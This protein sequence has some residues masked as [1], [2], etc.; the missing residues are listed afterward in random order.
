MFYTNQKA[1][2]DKREQNSYKYEKYTIISLDSIW[3]LIIRHVG[4]HV[5]HVSIFLNNSYY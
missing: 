4:V 5:L 3:S 1:I 2:T